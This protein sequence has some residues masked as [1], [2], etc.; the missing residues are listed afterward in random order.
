MRG[1]DDDDAVVALRHLRQHQVGEPVVGHDVVLQDLLECVVGQP[2]H[3]AEVGVGGGIADQNVDRG[4]SAC[5]S[6]ATRCSSWALSPMLAGT[7]VASPPPARI[8]CATSSQA[9][10]LRLEIDD[11][12][13]MGG[14]M[15]GDGA[16][17]AA[18]GAGDD[19]DLAVQPECV[20]CC[21]SIR[22]VSQFFDRICRAFYG[23]YAAGDR[24]HDIRFMQ[25]QRRPRGGGTTWIWT[26]PSSSSLNL[27]RAAIEAKLEEVRAAAESLLLADVAQPLDR[28]RRHEPRG[29]G[30][31]HQ[32]L[33][34]RRCRAP[35][36]SG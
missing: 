24:A 7:A 1:D 28:H 35:A 10:C 33:R 12:G 11:L 14:Q 13:A 9:G 34:W 20:H 29:V 21:L 3:R 36:R 8:A 15:L 30:K 5:A 4:R 16:A 17:D 23:I 25:V 31:A 22:V 18:A 2:R 32:G 6:R 26:R 27:D 19:G